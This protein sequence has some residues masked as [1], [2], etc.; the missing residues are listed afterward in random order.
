M[1]EVPLG[2]HEEISQLVENVRES[3]EAEEATFDDEEL[4]SLRKIS[5]DTHRDDLRENLSDLSAT[6]RRWVRGS[7][8]KA[9][10]AHSIYFIHFCEN[11]GCVCEANCTCEEQATFLFDTSD[12]ER[13]KRLYNLQ[14]SDDGSSNLKLALVY[15]P[16]DKVIYIYHVVYESNFMELDIA[17][18]TP[19][20]V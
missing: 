17:L 11:N 8:L 2:V 16:L 4:S 6:I 12:V 14:M 15:S 10:E 19:C 13:E 3:A 18:K 7:I 9:I 20:Y 1:N 5:N